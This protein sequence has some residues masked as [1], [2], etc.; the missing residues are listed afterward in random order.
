[1]GFSSSLLVWTC[2]VALQAAVTCPRTCVTSSRVLKVVTIET[3]VNL[4]EEVDAAILAV[5][6][7]AAVEEEIAAEATFPASILGNNQVFIEEFSFLLYEL[8]VKI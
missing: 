3:G 4:E 8:S 5:D 6:P 2:R 7:E 1:M